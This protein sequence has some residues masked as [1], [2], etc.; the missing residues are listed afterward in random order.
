MGV[1]PRN[2][3]NT[4]PSPGGATCPRLTNVAPPGLC[5]FML[6]YFQGFTPPATTYRPDGTEETAMMKR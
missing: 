2:I 1:S 4:N 6:Y 3:R 5:L